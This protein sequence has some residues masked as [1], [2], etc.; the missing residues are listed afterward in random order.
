MPTKDRKSR[1][2]APY[3]GFPLTPHPRGYWCKKIRGKL[4]YFGR[5]ADG[6][7]AAEALYE[8]QREDLHA[9]REPRRPDDGRLT[10][11]SM[12]N[13]YLDW[14]RQ[15][16][17]NGKIEERSWQ[18]SKETA[19]MFA[20][21]VGRN[22]PVDSLRVADFGDWRQ[23]L[24]SRYAVTTIVGHTARIRAAFRWAYEYELIERPMRYGVGFTPSSDELRRHRSESPD[25]Y[26]DAG[27]IHAIL[28]KCNRHV[29]AM[30][31]L[32]IN[33]AYGNMDCAR[34]TFDA[35]DL[36]GGWATF[37]RGKTGVR[38]RAK[39]WPE[40]TAAL[41]DSI[42][43]RPQHTDPALQ[44]T[45]FVTKY[46][47]AWDS[48]AIAKEF[49]KACSLSGVTGQGFYSLRHTFR[50]V[51]SDVGDDM[52]TRWVMG[53]KVP[54]IDAVYL[55]GHQATGRLEKISDHVRQWFLAGRPAEP[56]TPP[57]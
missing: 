2:D 47:N 45:V 16:A 4:H 1:P 51:A 15:R 27:D 22:L 3:P 21:F 33:C 34:L 26:I 36:A 38:R 10:V 30:V 40:T 13:R 48:G 8:L 12:L 28:G 49:S 50:K 35:L 25:S 39:L 31:L 46:R 24:D 53:H 29:A 37:A 19:A 20:A 43:A 32:G 57:Q 44:D 5:I 7:E 17:D 42:A 54:G 14:Q 11:A 18:E 41:L 9:G 23:H 55:G 56:A 52:A 6:W